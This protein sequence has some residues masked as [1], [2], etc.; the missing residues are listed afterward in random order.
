MSDLPPKRPEPVYLTCLRGSI[1]AAAAGLFAHELATWPG[2]AAAMTGALAGVIAGRALAASRVRTAA[3]C[4]GAL[5]VAFLGLQVEGLL[6]GPAW[7]PRLLGPRTALGAAEVLTFGTLVLGIVTGAR[8]LGA[9]YPTL[10]VLEVVAAVAVVVQLFAAHRGFQ[11]GEPRFFS[12][13]ALSRGYDPFQ[14]LLVIGGITFCAAVPLLFRPQR[15]AR[16]LV[17]LLLLLLVA[18][19]AV[20]WAAA[21][22]P[23][24]AADADGRQDPNDVPPPHTWEWTPPPMPDDKSQGKPVAVVNFHDDFVPPAGAY[25]FRTAAKSQFNGAALVPATLP[26]ADDDLP[27]ELPA[28]P[29]QLP[30]EPAAPGLVAEVPTTVGLIQ[31]LGPPLALVSAAALTPRENPNPK[32]FR[33]AYDV[34]SRAVSAAYGSLADRAAGSPAWSEPVRKLYLEGPADPRY[35][36]LAEE[37]LGTLQAPQ[38][39]SPLLCAL[40]FRRWVEKNTTYSLKVDYSGSADPTAQ[41]LFGDRRGYCVYIAHALVYLLRTQG[42]PARVGAGYMAETA[43][44]GQ[45]ASVMLQTT[46]GHAWPEIYLRGIGWITV[47]SFAEK[48]EEPPPPQPDKQTQDQMG[49]QL[50]PKESEKDKDQKKDQ[51]EEP[52]GPNGDGGSARLGKILVAGA[53]LLPLFVL[54]AIKAWRRTAPR[55]AAAGGLAR[56]VYRATLDRLADVGV[57]RQFGETREAFGRRVAALVPEFEAL[58]EAHLRSTLGHPDALAPAAWR[59][60]A[61]QTQA[62]IARAC[63]PWRRV[64]GLLNPISWLFAR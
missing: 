31:H 60:L 11:L 36:K 56:A 4:A 39:K 8:V 28:Q 23:D 7:L 21:Y 19:A 50:R 6:L 58:N 5:L 63:P 62:G 53:I 38:R 2:V 64:L 9:R 45:G 49:E 33:V 48:S 59:G 34:K 32:L 57:S 17:S 3:A 40:A 16:A 14:I 54:Y 52:P 10:G 22:A 47:D 25:Y 29:T 41:F 15:G 35:R 20:A 43:R 26:G 51:P 1:Y 27:R 12:D 30:G 42:I 13:W 37:I 44:R 18:C 55:F 46:D 61:A 24:R